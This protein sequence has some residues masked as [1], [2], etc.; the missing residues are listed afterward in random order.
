MSQA[1]DPPPQMPIQPNTFA[2]LA[3]GHLVWVED[4]DEQVA[5]VMFVERFR[6][7]AET[8]PAA[9]LAPAGSTPSERRAAV[10]PQLVP[11]PAH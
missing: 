7:T 5:R 10:G 2:R 4:V 11:L 9:D 6:A 1:T 3:S 8:V